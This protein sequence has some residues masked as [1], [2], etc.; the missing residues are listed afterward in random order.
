MITTNT[1]AT[2]SINVINKVKV[3]GTRTINMTDLAYADRETSEQ[4]TTAL[5]TELRQLHTIP[6]K[7][8]IMANKDVKYY[9][10]NK[11]L[12][13]QLG[14]FY[15]AGTEITID[16]HTFKTSGEPVFRYTWTT[17]HKGLTE[18]AKRYFGKEFTFDGL[19]KYNQ[20]VADMVKEYNRKVWTHTEEFFR[21]VSHVKFGQARV[22]QPNKKIYM[23]EHREEYLRKQLMELL[24]KTRVSFENMKLT[25]EQQQYLNTRRQAYGIDSDTLEYWEIP[26]ETEHGYAQDIPQVYLSKRVRSLRSS[27]AG[28]DLNEIADSNTTINSSFTTKQ[29]YFEAKAY[30]NYGL[31][32][33]YE[34]LNALEEGY[35]ICKKCGLP[36]KS[37]HAFCDV[38]HTLRPEPKT[39]I[40][41]AI[42]YFTTKLADKLPETIDADTH[43]KMFEFVL[44]ELGYT[45]TQPEEISFDVLK[46]K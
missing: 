10:I 11:E 38:C 18:H 39:E 4:A 9:Y 43:A 25:E 1:Q 31:L 27:Y 24:P 45:D 20:Y 12:V 28:G 17:G 15:G 13:N 22:M 32:K 23:E 21:Q 16:N 36:T 3:E 41:A 44:E 30:I 5:V 6:E 40:E 35:T 19:Y 34:R 29:Q 46:S 37:E 14:Y 8:V 7:I 42:K 2:V 26:V 33:E